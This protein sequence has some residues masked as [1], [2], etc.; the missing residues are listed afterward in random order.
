MLKVREKEAWSK[1]HDS[2][3]NDLEKDDKKY[4]RRVVRLLRECLGETAAGYIK[5]RYSTYF[6]WDVV[7]RKYLPVRTG[8]KALEVGSA[9]GENLLRFHRMFGYAPYGVEYS[10]IGAEL[11]KELFLSHNIDARNVICSDFFSDEFQAKYREYFNIVSSFGFIEHFSNV[12]EVIDKHLNLLAPRG[13]LVVAIPNFRGINYWLMRFFKK[14]N[15]DSHNL[16]IMKK[17]SFKKL[18]SN[19]QLSTLYCD[20]AGTFNFFEFF[21]PSMG[22]IKQYL[23][24]CGSLF[25]LF[26]NL[27]FNLTLRKRGIETPF[28]SPFLIYI[29]Q[30]ADASGSTIRSGRF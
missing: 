8:Y 23:Q 7:L 5:K 21:N 6:L 1:I 3:K 19:R 29:G 10:K 30:K 26:L 14:E 25:Q 16:I 18:F 22:K 12:E 4:I 27:C 9:P 11:N 20:Y 17:H 28:T 24:R 15:I 13:T 2:I